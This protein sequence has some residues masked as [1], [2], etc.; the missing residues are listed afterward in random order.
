MDVAVAIFLILILMIFFGA[1]VFWCVVFGFI[2]HP[3][4]FVIAF[5]IWLFKD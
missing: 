5:V 3:I 4:W 2:F 1:P